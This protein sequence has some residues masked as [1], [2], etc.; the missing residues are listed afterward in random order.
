MLV[1]D[2]PI[3]CLRLVDR[4][5]N[6]TSQFLG[7]CSAPGACRYGNDPRFNYPRAII[8]N[9]FT[10][11][12]LLLADAGTKSVRIINMTSW[13]VGSLVRWNS[14]FVPKGIVYQKNGNLYM[15]QDDPYGGSSVM[16]VDHVSGRI[17]VM[18]GSIALMVLS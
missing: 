9:S 15:S 6:E 16:E 12:R 3:N 1:L 4:Q 13:R 11:K 18:A 2:M 8:H 5:T 10:S 14:T 17:T 7:N